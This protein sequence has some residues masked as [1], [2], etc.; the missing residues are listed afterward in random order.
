MYR[1]LLFICTLGACV[2]LLVIPLSPINSSRLNT[3]FIVCA[4]GAWAGMLFFAW[5]MKLIRYFLFLIPVLL[6]IPFCLPKAGIEEKE[7]RADY[8]QRLVKFEKTRYVWGG[9]S[10]RGIDCSGLPRRAFRDA[11]LAYGMKHANGLA[12]RAYLEHWWFDAS[13]NAL[14]EGYRNYTKPVG[15][16]GTIHTMDYDNLL[17]GD[18]AVTTGR[19]HV[20]VYVGDEQWIQA[21]PGIGFVAVLNGRT[22]SNVWFTIP[23]TIHRWQ[24]LS[25]P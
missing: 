20:L 13:A 11:L 14:G 1:R 21:D 6:A 23:V 17:P 9:E 4:I 22:S 24:M 10:S 12:F 19:G 8:L 3:L 2:G 18:L 16:S 5:R 25:H 15:L 7:L